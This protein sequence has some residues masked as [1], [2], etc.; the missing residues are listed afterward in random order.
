MQINVNEKKVYLSF[1]F[2]I[3]IL[4]I[5]SL[6]DSNIIYLSN[7]EIIDNQGK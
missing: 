4:T 2:S 6:S 7:N 1:I 3:I 5:N